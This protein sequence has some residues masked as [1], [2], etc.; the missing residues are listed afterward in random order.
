MNIL[1]Y[2][3]ILLGLSSCVSS[4]ATKLESREDIIVNS[5]N[6][7]SALF[8]EYVL[9]DSSFVINKYPIDGEIEALSEVPITPRPKQLFSA[10]AKNEIRL[11][12]LGEVRWV[13]LGLEPST[14]WPMTIEFLRTNERLKLGKFDPSAGIINS[15]KFKFNNQETILEFKLERGL[16][17][18]SSEIFVSHLTSVNGT[19]EIL[20]NSKSNLEVVINEL[21]E[22][23]SSSAPSTGTSLVALNL[24][25]SNKTEVITEGNGSRIIKLRVNFARAWAATRRSLQIAGYNIIDED[26]NAG[27]FYLEYRLRRSILNRTSSI[28]QIQIMVSEINPNECIIST[29]LLDENQEISDEI[30]SQINQA[31]S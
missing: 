7:N 21:Y 2:F 14:V 18:S 20:P 10:A 15:S 19:W 16:Q 26:R 9:E 31:L 24:N 11:H 5:N 22:F 1:K 29:D 17:Q 12:K 13:Y 8:S 3:I 28:S 23:L 4:N 30:I 27:K 25:A 6:N